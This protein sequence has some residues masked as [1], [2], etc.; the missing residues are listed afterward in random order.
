MLKLITMLI[1][2]LFGMVAQGQISET[3]IVT[4][5]KQVEVKNAE[6]IY[7]ESNETSLTVEARDNAAL[8]Q[9]S[10]EITA[11]TLKIVNRSNDS[12][13]KVYLSAE[14]VASFKAGSNSKI[15][16]AGQITGSN[17]SVILN[18]NAVFTGKIATMY[19]AT[20]EANGQSS[21]K[22][23][24][25]CGTFKGVFTDDS[26]VIV[27]GI[28]AVAMI[29]TGNTATFNARNFSAEKLKIDAEGNSKVWAYADNRIDITVLEG[30]KVIYNGNPKKVDLNEFATSFA[31]EKSNDALSYKY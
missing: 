3:R 25:E 10:T 24:V 5:F 14:N 9:V 19:K 30:A 22:G 31:K 28:A 20:L 2:F 6:L 21:F 18:S 29:H 26:K 13:V 8:E 4:G 12:Q 27:C 11:G 17:V 23:H 1:L 15:T 7:I 16:V